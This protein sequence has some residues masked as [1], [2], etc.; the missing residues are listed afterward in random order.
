MRQWPMDEDRR[1]FDDL[2]LLAREIEAFRLAAK[3][4]AT[5]EIETRTPTHEDAV[6]RADVN[7]EPVAGNSS[8]LEISPPGQADARVLVLAEILRLRHFTPDGDSIDG[9][10][11]LSLG[12]IEHQIHKIDPSKTIE[13][14]SPSSISRMFRKLFGNGGHTEYKRLANSRNGLESL[15]KKLDPEKFRDRFQYEFKDGP[16]QGLSGAET[17]ET[18]EMFS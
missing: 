15:R 3:A 12:E 2:A 11:F 14:W 13:G 16:F 7:A 18:D 6:A 1:Q 8:G 17:D 4:S 5:P 10:E 9:V